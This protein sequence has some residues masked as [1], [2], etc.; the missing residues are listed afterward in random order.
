MVNQFQGSKDQPPQFTRG[1]GLSCGHAERKAMSMAILDR[2]LKARE[3]GEAAEYPAQQEEFVLYHADNVEASGFVE[4]L[5]LPHY[6]DFQGELELL[7]K[8]RREQEERS[9]ALK[10]A[11]E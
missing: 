7:R 11:A 4:H 10:E 2:S 3:F 1:Y 5:K 9:A 8:I 6:V